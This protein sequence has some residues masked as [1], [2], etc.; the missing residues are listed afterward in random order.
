MLI[1]SVC[2]RMVSL[3]K[4]LPLQSESLSTLLFIVILTVH[5]ISLFDALTRLNKTFNFSVF[6]YLMYNSISSGTLKESVVPRKPWW[7]YTRS[8]VDRRGCILKGA[9]WIAV[10]GEGQQNA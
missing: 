10:I 6:F 7:F 3:V 5:L 1:I 4:Y 9:N 2:M 8:P